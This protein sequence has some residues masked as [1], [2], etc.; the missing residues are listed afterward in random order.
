MQQ[1]SICLYT[2]II[3]FSKGRR[4]FKGKFLTKKKEI[5]LYFDFKAIDLLSI[6]AQT[7]V[8]L[9]C[10]DKILKRYFYEM[11]MLLTKLHIVTSRSN[12]FSK[13][14]NLYNSI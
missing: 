6:M 13:V 3:Y 2:C 11:V 5:Y 9:Q 14:G 1:K 8:K 10:Y 7:H 12:N 4:F